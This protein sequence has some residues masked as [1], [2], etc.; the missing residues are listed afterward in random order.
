MTKLLMVGC[1][2][3][4]GCC[5]RYLI[6]II[7]VKG[8]GDSFPYGTL[9][10]NVLGS[11]LIGFIFAS[12]LTVL[13]ISDNMKLFVMTG[14]LGGLTTFSTFSLDTIS[15]IENK[16]ILLATSNIM[17][18]VVFGLGGVLTGKYFSKFFEKIL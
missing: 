3:F 5:T 13:D 16:K 15:L 7:A 17:L 9:I 6:S 4:V 8:L 10:V 2:G 14:I 11:F 1:G 18:N 12:S